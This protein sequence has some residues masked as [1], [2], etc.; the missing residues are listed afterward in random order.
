MSTEKRKGARLPER[1]AAWFAAFLLAVLIIITLTGAV[2][3]R[4]VTSAELHLSV[5][6]DPGMLDRQLQAIYSDIDLMAEEYGFPAGQVKEAVSR[7]ELEDFN[8]KAAAWW[9]QL[10]TEGTSGTIPRWNSGRIESVIR[11]A[12][13]DGILLEEPQ[14][15]VADLISAI[16]GTV[17]PV[18][19]TVTGF[20]TGLV[21]DK[22]DLRGIVRSSR[23]LPALGLVLILGCAG[24]TALLLGRDPFSLLKYY[25]TAAAAAGTAVL[26]G[27]IAFALFRPGRM[28]AEASAGLADQFATLAGKT[29]PAV[30]LAGA[31][32]LAAGYLCLFLYYRKAGRNG[33]AAEKTA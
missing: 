5:A 27:C 16:G 11:T 21:N 2:F 26:A 33:K 23:K 15:V 18:R 19:E 12:A 3:L 32:L 20:G 22:I 24:L 6:A 13:E 17:F 10:L 30:L 9:T 25:G 28:I 7:E 29:G 31:G 14:T 8:R 4:A 1:G